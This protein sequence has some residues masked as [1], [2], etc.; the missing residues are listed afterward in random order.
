MSNSFKRNLL[1]VVLFISLAFFPLARAGATNVYVGVQI[2][3]T[4]PLKIGG[5]ADPGKLWCLPTNTTM[6]LVTGATPAGGG[7]GGT[8]ITPQALTS[9]PVTTVAPTCPGG[10]IWSG[11]LNLTINT[12]YTIRMIMPAPTFCSGYQASWTDSTC[13]ETWDV[14]GQNK[15][16]NEICARYGQTPRLGGTGTQ[17]YSYPGNAD[18]GCNYIIK[19]VKGSA[20]TSCT[21]SASNYS[22]YS[23]TTGAC[24]YPANYYSD[25]TWSDPSQV[26]VCACLPI[27]STT[28]GNFNFSFTTPGTL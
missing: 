16:C 6:G 9:N 2:I 19:G 28:L 5:V 22:Y 11:L 1:F 15:N 18:H 23:K 12:T 3:S 17:C 7:T 26:R 8:Y 10:T 21:A 27:Y 25:C 14:V 24:F 20:C 4:E 13:Y